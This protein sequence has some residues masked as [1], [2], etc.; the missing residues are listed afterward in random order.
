MAAIHP[1]ENT[2]GDVDR[3]MGSASE[4]TLLWFIGSD[5]HYLESTSEY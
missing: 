3:A 5:C 2:H 1:L 4:A